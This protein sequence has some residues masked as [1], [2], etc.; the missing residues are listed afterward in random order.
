[1]SA[2]QA[3][4]GK[5]PPHRRLQPLLQSFSWILLGL[6]SWSLRPVLI[7]SLALALSS[8][9]VWWAGEWGRRAALDDLQGAA[10]ASLH[11]PSAALR[12]SLEKYRA[13][14]FVLARDNEGA[15]LLRD[16]SD[17]TM[18]DRANRKLE[19]LSDGTRAAAGY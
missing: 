4:P 6:G 16:P 5:P 3:A 15:T 8:V 12:S 7:G 2:P 13:V 17:R 1:M 10:S 18:I 11:L 9:I 19:A 14:A